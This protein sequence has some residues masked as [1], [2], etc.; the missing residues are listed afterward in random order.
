MYYVNLLQVQYYVNLME[1]HGRARLLDTDMLPIVQSVLRD[2]RSH[3]M[4]TAEG[5]SSATAAGSRSCHRRRPANPC[6]RPLGAVVWKEVMQEIEAGLA[7]AKHLADCQ[8]RL[9]ARGALM[10]VEGHCSSARAS[11]ENADDDDREFEPPN[12]NNNN[13]N[14]MANAGESE[15]GGGVVDKVCKPEPEPPDIK[16]EEE[17]DMG[18]DA[19]ETMRMDEGGGELEEPVADTATVVFP[20]EC[21]IF[22]PETADTLANVAASAL[23]QCTFCD[24]TFIDQVPGSRKI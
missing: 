20:V 12:H 7:A 16:E 10:E 21:D 8:Q 13:N 22:L 6:S 23:E 11:V 5:G 9:L 14:R 24:K 19:A 15:E 17:E 1:A 4:T 3:I 2:F 18:P